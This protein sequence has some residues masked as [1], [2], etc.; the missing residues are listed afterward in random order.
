MRGENSFFG[1]ASTAADTAF[2]VAG[3]TSVG[4]VITGDEP[5]DIPTCRMLSIAAMSASPVAYR[6]TGFL[7]SAFC[8]TLSS[9]TGSPWRTPVSVRGDSVRLRVRMM[10]ALGP[11]N[12]GSPASIS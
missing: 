1:I 3:T 6:S 4:A 10:R 9:A 2:V 8:T 7:A 11:T 12:G 5:D